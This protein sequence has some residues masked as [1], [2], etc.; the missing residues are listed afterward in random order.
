MILFMLCMIIHWVASLSAHIVHMK[1]QFRTI[2]LEHKLTLT[3][4]FL[5]VLAHKL[6]K[7]I[8]LDQA[9]SFVTGIH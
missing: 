2:L 9:I 6:G 5:L 3:N 1:D 4:Y 8:R 7:E